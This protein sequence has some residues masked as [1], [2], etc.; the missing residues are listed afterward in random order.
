MKFK[1]KLDN[2]LLTK[3]WLTILMCVVSLMVI[4][5]ALVL[6]I[7]GNTQNI[8]AYVFYLLSAICLT[9][10]VYVLIIYSKIIKENTIKSIKKVK[11]LNNL[12]EDFGYRTVIFA[13]TSFVINVAY[14]IFQAVI[15]IMAK[16]IWLGALAVYYIVISIIRGWLVVS[17]RKNTNEDQTKIKAY[18]KCGV[19]LL[20]LNVA[21]IPAIVLIVRSNHVFD[22]AGLMIYVMAT[23]TFYKLTLSIFNLVKARRQNDHIIKSIKSLGFADSLVSIFALQTAMFA[24][25]AEDANVAVFNALTG[26]VVSIVIIVIGIYMIVKGHAK[27]KQVQKGEFT[28]E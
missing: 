8:L 2:F 20:I 21:L 28:N 24:A 25:F 15:A 6:V 5:F 26:G 13:G 11:F 10:V 22:Y 12:L 9:F 27:L 23:Y 19:M 16:S 18:K 1:Q 7:M 17:A 4:A 3:K 14:A